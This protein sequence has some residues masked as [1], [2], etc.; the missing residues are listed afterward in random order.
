MSCH[1]TYLGSCRDTRVMRWLKGLTK[2]NFYG[3]RLL[4]DVIGKFAFI[5]YL[6]RLCNLYFSLCEVCALYPQIL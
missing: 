6:R 4:N 5:G 3:Y 1:L 2:L